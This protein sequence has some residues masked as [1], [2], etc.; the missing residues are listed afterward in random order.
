MLSK[1]SQKAGDNSNQVYIENQTVGI[2]ESRAT[3]IA[4][5]QAEIAIR[6]KFTAEAEVKASSRIQH[7]DRKIIAKL[8]ALELL[9]IFGEPSFLSAFQKAQ[10]SAAQSDRETDYDVLANL[11]VERAVSNANVAKAA[12]VRAIEVVDL[13]D[14]EALA[15]LT[16]LW[17]VG[18]TTAN[19]STPEVALETLEASYASILS[20]SLPVGTWWID[21]LSALNLVRVDRTLRFKS[22]ID[23]FLKDRPAWACVGLTSDEVVEHSDRL[24]SLIGMGVDPSIF[25]SHPY[26]EERFVFVFNS[27]SDAVE[28]IRGYFEGVGKSLDGVDWPAVGEF[29]EFLDK[30]DDSCVENLKNYIRENY[31]NVARVMAW[32]GSFGQYAD[33]THIGAALAFTNAKR[34]DDLKGLSSLEDML[35]SYGMG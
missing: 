21:H 3:E 27:K 4:R 1:G 22:Y 13:V 34:F 31:P 5:I 7:A 9:D 24:K 29:F 14:D 6:E 23:L 26:N 25:I 15:G 19:A 18:T 30:V 35:I 2:T 11:L 8:T 16:A 20:G 17:F 32:W 28:A 10:I 33:T 12:V